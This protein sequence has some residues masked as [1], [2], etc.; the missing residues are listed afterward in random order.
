M[1]LQGY[2]T[3]APPSPNEAA[4]LLDDYLRMKKIRDKVK[5][6]FITP[7]PRP[8]P[9]EPVSRVIQPLFEKR[10]IKFVTFFNVDRVDPTEHE[11]RSLE[12][13]SVKFDML[14]L[15]P[16]HRGADV[17][18]KSGIGDADGWIRTDKYSMRISGY[19]D[20]YA[21][22]DATDIP[23]AKTG[24][25]AHLE[26]RVAVKNIVNTIRGERNLYTYSGRT[27]CPFE[28]GS[29]KATFVVGSYNV[30][31]KQMYPNRV[32]HAMKKMFSR[33][34]WQTLSGRWDWFFSLYFGKTCLKSET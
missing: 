15:V 14:I 27:N 2:R 10:D 8:Y 3:N 34:Y 11:V 18:V 26:A 13:T 29:G 33:I 21:I 24:V 32:R 31:V 1:E 23:I 20:A 6:T 12:R 19:V 25:A 17:I 5:I 30:P 7:Y 16:P 22:G 28:V 9:S 4:F